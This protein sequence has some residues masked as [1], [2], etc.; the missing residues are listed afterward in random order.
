TTVGTSILRAVGMVDA[1]IK[2]PPLEIK[3]DWFHYS[4]IRRR[5]PFAGY[6]RFGGMVVKNHHPAILHIV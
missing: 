3:I 6:E 5:I 2:I 4:S 1:D